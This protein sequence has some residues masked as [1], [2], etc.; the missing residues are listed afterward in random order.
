M[1]MALVIA[2][3]LFSAGNVKANE[4]SLSADWEWVDYGGEDELPDNVVTSRNGGEGNPICS[5]PVP[6]TSEYR[7]GWLKL[8]NSKCFIPGATQDEKRYAAIEGIRVLVHRQPDQQKF[9]FVPYDE[10]IAGPQTWPWNREICASY[11]DGEKK[12][13]VGFLHRGHRCISVGG[14]R[15]THVLEKPDFMVLI[16][17]P[18]EQAEAEAENQI[19]QEEALDNLSDAME[20]MFSTCVLDVPECKSSCEFVNRDY[21]ERARNALKKARNRIEEG[22]GEVRELLG[23]LAKDGKRIA[24]L[25]RHDGIAQN[26]AYFIADFG[27][28]HRDNNCREYCKYRNTK[29]KDNCG[30]LS[31]EEKIAYFESFRDILT[32]T[33]T[34]FDGEW[35]GYT[36]LIRHNYCDFGVPWGALGGCKRSNEDWDSYGNIEVE[37]ETYDRTP[38]ERWL[39]REGR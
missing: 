24:P 31:R 8:R 6:G 29:H 18:E 37:G 7:V 19:V 35:V 20:E 1:N 26:L 5:A 27:A 3:M 32:E 12:V 15:K 10:W 22:K 23:R 25:A 4:P 17:T 30:K 13:K 39:E 33:C 38:L 36:G 11:P 21:R 14:G 2:V 34:A 16:S 9:H 28:T